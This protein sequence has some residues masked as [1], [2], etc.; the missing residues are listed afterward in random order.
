MTGTVPIGLNFRM[1]IVLSSS[2]TPQYVDPSLLAPR[3]VGAP[4]HDDVPAVE[5]R[6]VLD[7]LGGQRERTARVSAAWA[8]YGQRA[9]G[10]VL[11]FARAR[12]HGR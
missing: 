5:S 8:A 9:R 7:N 10:A 4:A 11:L 2:R 3:V 12:A 1:E 6:A